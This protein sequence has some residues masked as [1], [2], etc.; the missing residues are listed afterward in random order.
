MSVAIMTSCQNSW[1]IQLKDD[2]LGAYPIS[3]KHASRRFLICIPATVKIAWSLANTGNC[4]WSENYSIDAWGNLQISP[5]GGKA[6]GGNFTLSGNAQNRP[7]GLAYD[8][9]GNLMSYLSAT[10]TY[11]PENRLSST[12]GMSYT[13][14]GN[15]ERMLKS[16]TS[17]GAAVKRYWSMGG[18]TLAEGDGTGNLTAE[19]IYFGGKRVARVDLPTNTVHYYLSD[20]LGSTSI[21]VSSAGA[22]EEESDYYP[23]GTEVNVTGPGLNELKFTGKRRDPES[24]LDYFNARYF[25]SPIGR[26]MS[27]DPLPWLE[28][29][30][31]KKEEQEKFNNWISNPQNL[32]TYSYVD[33]NP[34]NHT[35]PTGMNA[36]GTSN[37]SNCKVTIT[38]TDRTKDKNGNYNDNYSGVKGQANYNAT[39]TVSVNGKEAGTFLVK[40]TPS[41]PKAAATIANGTYSATLTTHGN[42][43]AIRLQPTNNIPTI[44]PNSSRNDGASMATGILIHKAGINNFTGV[45]HDGRAV[46]EG[47][48]VVC[49]SQFGAFKGAT[50]MAPSAGAP[51]HHFTVVLNTQENQP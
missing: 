22:V 5:M 4:P 36:C 40:T 31:G 20:H 24:Q 6:H 12:A 48:Q 38:I 11:D 15:G 44:G 23:F 47:C 33:N 19:Y 32:N 35:D 17:T 34:L 30:H 29:Q 25:E 45:G 7:T 21:V 39:A 13:Y 18:N 41:D 51:Q 37:D 27:S 14:D 3:R 16:N 10:Y 2:R 50:G 8:A 49:T 46:S 28:W 42:D 43:I 1:R 9:A 26:F